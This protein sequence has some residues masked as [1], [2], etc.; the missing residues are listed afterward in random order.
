MAIYGGV[1][2]VANQCLF[3]WNVAVKGAI[4][5]KWKYFAKIYYNLFVLFDYYL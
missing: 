3:I 2:D 5:T 1:N 4:A